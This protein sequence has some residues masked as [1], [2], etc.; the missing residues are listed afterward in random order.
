MSGQ[1]CENYDVKRKQFTVTREM[2]TAIA[3]ISARYSKYAF[4]FFCYITN[5]L[6]TGLEGNSE[7]CF[8]RI[9]MF[10]SASSRETLRLSGN[11]IHC[12]PRDQSLSVYYYYTTQPLMKTPLICSMTA[13]LVPKEPKLIYDLKWFSCSS[14]FSILEKNLCCL[15]NH[16]VYASFFTGKYIYT[17]ATPRSAGDNAKLQLLLPASQDKSTSCLTFFYHMYG[18]SMGTLNVF[19]RDTI[20]FTTS[21]DHGYDWKK[22][23]KTVNSGGFVSML[24][25]FLSGRNTRLKN[26]NSTISDVQQ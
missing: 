20:I 8:P 10:P 12:S 16:T 23:T 1:Y 6:M 2:L 14:A 9:S 13:H 11:K 4:V 7:F 26:V 21:G 19:N 18:S 15:T 3:G 5:H 22:V 24:F 25:L 17:E